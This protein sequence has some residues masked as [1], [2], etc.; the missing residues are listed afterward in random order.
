MALSCG[1]HDSDRVDGSV[2]WALP[3]VEARLVDT[4]TE[5]VIEGCG[6]EGEIQLRGKNVFA[7]YW[8][9][10]GATKESFV[11]DIHG[12]KPWFK[13]GDVAVRKEVDGAGKGLSGEWATGP[14]Y[15]IQGRK[16]VDI[17]KRGGEKV[18]ALEVERELLSL[19]VSI[20]YFLPLPLP[21]PCM[22]YFSLL[23]Y[24]RPQIVE[25][26]VVGLPSEQWGQKVAVVLVLH[27]EAASSGRNGKSWGAMDMRRALKDRLAGYKIPQEMKVLGS[28]PRNAMG[29]VNKK[30]LVKEVFGV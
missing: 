13:T 26:A 24:V 17:I 28:I 12:G 10:E 18:S 6:V 11:D 14:M 15:F 3:G 5:S 1:L 4:E 22:I 9:N 29:K 2:G 8:G 25:A 19:Y 27:P 21:L 23:T 16:S 20:P 30:A 7:S